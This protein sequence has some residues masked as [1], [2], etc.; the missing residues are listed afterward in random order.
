MQLRFPFAASRTRNLEHAPE[1]RLVP[2]EG[3]VHDALLL[4]AAGYGA[5]MAALSAPRR[6]EEG[7]RVRAE[8]SALAGA[9]AA[10]LM[11][12]SG[13]EAAA[14][15]RTAS[16]AHRALLAEVFGERVFRTIP[17]AL[18][19]ARQSHL[20]AVGSALR[21]QALE[22]HDSELLLGQ[23]R[24]GAMVAFT[25]TATLAQ[26]HVWLLGALYERVEGWIEGSGG[27]ALEREASRWFFERWRPARAQPGD[28][29]ARGVREQEFSLVERELITLN[30]SAVE[31]VAAQALLGDA[32]P[33]QRRMA[34]ALPR[35]RC[36]VWEVTRRSD[37]WTELRHPLGG[38]LVR[39][40]DHAPELSYGAGDMMLGRLIP[41]DEG[42][43]LRSP[44]AAV[45]PGLGRG[46]ARTLAEGLEDGSGNLSDQVL[47][48]AAIQ[49][50]LGV[51]GLPREVRPRASPDAAAEI[52]RDLREA[53]EAVGA[54][55]RVAPGDVP[56]D[57]ASIPDT[58]CYRFSVDIVLNDYI[59]ALFPI[60][61]KSRTYREMLRR[62]ERE[63]KERG[64]R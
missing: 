44:G 36:G 6:Q 60:A 11:E 48:E 63:A 64:R 37:G 29:F 40:A 31:H 19:H 1:P 35:S 8:S 23:H 24:G 55:E 39:V 25:A 21:E 62:R 56:P 43:W 3:E 54:A 5:A 50:A 18:R 52:L 38:R 30:A 58:E 46:F 53:L 13:P 15:L 59:G 32:G 49:T 34:A 20:M 17:K 42:T 61:R 47:V 28:E 27:P 10:V 14:A 2:I 33:K 22:Y 4:L 45:V 26:A 16:E 7:E 51:R 57:L 12:G 41:L 9:A